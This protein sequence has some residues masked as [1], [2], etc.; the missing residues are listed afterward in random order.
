LITKLSLAIGAES[1]VLLSLPAIVITLAEIKL[2]CEG[3][4]LLTA[5]TASRSRSL[6]SAVTSRSPAIRL[7]GRTAGGEPFMETNLVA[8]GSPN[9]RYPVEVIEFYLLV[10]TLGIMVMPS[11][12]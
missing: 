8:S 5:R 12:A 9:D 3:A 1:G 10:Y 11:S 7:I 4:G 2:A 6:I